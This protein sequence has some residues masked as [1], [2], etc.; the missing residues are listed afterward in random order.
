MRF[1]V[2]C[3]NLLECKSGW[4]F[5][6]ALLH[7][8]LVFALSVELT[9]ENFG[10]LLKS[11]GVQELLEFD[12]MDPPPEDNMLNSM[13][14]VSYMLCCIVILYIIIS[15]WYYS[16]VLA[17]GIS[18]SMICSTPWTRFIIYCI[19]LL[20]ISYDILLLYDISYYVF[21]FHIDI[22]IMYSVL[23]FAFVDPPPERNFLNSMYNNDNILHIYTCIIVDREIVCYANQILWYTICLNNVPGLTK[24]KYENIRNS[25]L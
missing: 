25:M 15:Y 6:S 17:A 3:W 1:F 20:Y 21:V 9:C 16:I 13:Y 18:Q 22:I 23:E 2:S 5:L 11:L 14:Q 10:Q 12:F 8:N 19:V 24:V 4:N 7:L